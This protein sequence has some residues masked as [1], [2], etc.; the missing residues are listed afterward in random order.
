[1]PN[2]REE[3]IRTL[4]DKLELWK[5]QLDKLEVQAALAKAEAKVEYH[6]QITDLRHKREEAKRKLDELQHA[7]EHAWKDMKAGLELAW[8]AVEAAFSS[9]RSRF[10]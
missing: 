8:D 9:A 2:T 1:M 3:Y 10:K 6:E 5:A 4:R 7:G